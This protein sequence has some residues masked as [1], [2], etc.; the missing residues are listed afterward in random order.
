MSTAPQSLTHSIAENAQ[1]LL[2]QQA[3]TLR[4]KLKSAMWLP[5]Q[6]DVTL[7]KLDVI[8]RP[9]KKEHTTGTGPLLV[10]QKNPLAFAALEA[11]AAL[12]AELVHWAKMISRAHG[13]SP[14][15]DS[16]RAI[17][18]YVHGHVA[19][20]SRT[21]EFPDAWVGIVTAV[22]NASSVVD[23]PEDEK[24]L[25]EENTK[26]TG[27]KGKHWT[28]LPDSVRDE[29]RTPAVIVEA[30]RPYK[31]S[32]LTTKRIATWGCNKSIETREEE[33][34]VYRDGE[35]TMELVRVYCVGEVVDRWVAAKEAKAKADAMERTPKQI[36]KADAQR[37][38]REHKKARA[39]I[40]IAEGGAL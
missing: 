30:L 3:D 34:P 32:Q 23:L 7:A 39:A 25:V 16:T 2:D 19:W 31:V 20:L 5:Q 40:A 11:H 13:T 33:R 24:F 15:N 21:P 6:L 12:R 29:W 36:A 37:R 26:G 28:R 14:V 10:N 1:A 18:V 35:V 9:E 22:E 8:S 17:A 38:W 4:D 27:Y